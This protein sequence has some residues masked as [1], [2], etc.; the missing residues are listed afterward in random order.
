MLN[1]FK[2]EFELI[3]SDGGSTDR[4]LDVAKGKNVKV[5][6]SPKGRGTQLNAGAKAANGEFLIFLH[7]DTFLPDNAFNLIEEFFTDPAHKICRFLLGFDF[8]H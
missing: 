2:E 8:N 1:S 6:N 4:T 5:I 3:I 7:A